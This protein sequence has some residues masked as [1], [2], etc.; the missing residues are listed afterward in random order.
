MSS[1]SIAKTIAG[2][3]IAGVALASA[4][5]FNAQ[6]ISNKQRN[7][8]KS[9]A[10]RAAAEKQEAKF[11]RQRSR[12]EYSTKGTSGNA[13]ERF[14]QMFDLYTHYRSVPTNIATE[15]TNLRTSLENSF[16]SIT[17]SRS[18]H[19]SVIV[20][21]ACFAGVF[22]NRTTQRYDD[23][24]DGERM[25]EKLQ[26]FVGI[27]VED[28][29][30][31]PN[32][33]LGLGSMRLSPACLV[34]VRRFLKQWSQSYNVLD[35]FKLSDPIQVKIQRALHIKFW[36]LARSFDSAGAVDLPT[37]QIVTFFPT[38]VHKCELSDYDKEMLELHE[39]FT[40]EMKIKWTITCIRKLEEFGL[41][42]TPTTTYGTSRQ[43][44]PEKSRETQISQYCNE[45]GLPIVNCELLPLDFIIQTSESSIT[46][47]EEQ[48][49][50]NK[51][52]LGF[53]RV[54]KHH[55]NTKN[56][57]NNKSKTHTRDRLPSL[58]ESMQKVFEGLSTNVLITSFVVSN[59]NIKESFCG[60]ISLTSK[61][62]KIH[63]CYKIE[64]NLQITKTKNSWFNSHIPYVAP[65][66]IPDTA[67]SPQ[68]SRNAIRT[69]NRAI[70]AHNAQI[71][72]NNLIRTKRNQQKK[73]MKLMYKN[74]GWKLNDNQTLK[75]G[76]LRFP[77]GARV[78][79]NTRS[80]QTIAGI[81]C[82]G[83]VIAHHYMASEGRRVPYQIRLDN[84]ELVFAPLDLN[85]CIRKLNVEWDGDWILGKKL[86]FDVLTTKIDRDKM[87]DETGRI[88]T[89]KVGQTLLYRLEAL[90]KENGHRALVGASIEHSAALNGK[91]KTVVDV[92]D[93][94]EELN[95][96]DYVRL[97][98]LES[99]ENVKVQLIANLLK[100]V[101]PA[102]TDS[103]ASR[104][105]EVEEY[106]KALL[107]LLMYRCQTSSATKTNLYPRD[108]VAKQSVYQ[109]MLEGSPFTFAHDT[110]ETAQIENTLYQART[111]KDNYFR[112]NILFHDE[113]AKG[114]SD[115]WIWGC[116]IVFSIVMICAVVLIGIVNS[117]TEL[118]YSLTIT[119][120]TS[121]GQSVYPFIHTSLTEGTTSLKYKQIGMCL[122][123][124]LC[125]AAVVLSAVYCIRQYRRWGKFLNLMS[126]IFVETMGM[127]TIL[128]ALLKD[129]ISS[130]DT[131]FYAYHLFFPKTFW[132]LFQHPKCFWVGL[133]KNF[134][135]QATKVS[136]IMITINHLEE[137]CES[138]ENKWQDRL[139][140]VHLNKL[141]KQKV[142]KFTEV[143]RLLEIFD[144]MAT[145]KHVDL[146]AESVSMFW[147]DYEMSDSEDEK[148]EEDKDEDKDIN[149]IDQHE[150][151]QHETNKQSGTTNTTNTATSHIHFEIGTKVE[152]CTST[153]NDGSNVW[154]M[155]EVMTSND[156]TT[157]LQIKLLDDN[158]IIKAQPTSVT[159]LSRSK[160]K[161]YYSCKNAKKRKTHS[162][163]KVQRKLVHIEKVKQK[164]KEYSELMHSSNTMEEVLEI[165]IPIDFEKILKKRVKDNT[166][167][168]EER[169]KRGEATESDIIARVEAAENKITEN[170]DNGDVYFGQMEGDKPHGYGTSTFAHGGKYVGEYKN[171][172][173]DG[174]G[175]YTW[176]DGK[177]YVGQY[178]DGKMHGQGTHTKANGTILHSGEWENDK[179]MGRRHL[180]YHQEAAKHRAKGKRKNN[181]LNIGSEIRRAMTK[182]LKKASPNNRPMMLMN[183]NKKKNM[184][185]DE[186][187]EEEEDNENEEDNKDEEES[188]DE[189]DRLNSSKKL[190][191]ADL[192]KNHGYKLIRQKTHNVF[193]R[194]IRNEKTGDT[195]SQ[196]V[197]Q[198]KTPSDYRAVLN[199][200]AVL[201]RLAHEKKAFEAGLTMTE[202]EEQIQQQNLATLLKNERINQEKHEKLKM[203]CQ[204]E[205]KKRNDQEK[206]QVREQKRASRLLKKKNQEE[207][208]K[209]E[210]LIEFQKEA[211]RR[212]EKEEKRR[213][214][215]EKRKRYMADKEERNREI[216]RENE[217]KQVEAARE[218]VKKD[219][220]DKIAAQK[221]A[222]EEQ[223]KAQKRIEIRMQRE[224]EEKI[225]AQ[226]ALSMRMKLEKE[227]KRKK[228]EK[229]KELI[230][231]E[232]ARVVRRE[233]E[234]KQMNAAAAAKK[235]ATT[236]SG[237]AHRSPSSNSY[238][239]TYSSWSTVPT[240]QP[241]PGFNNTSSPPG[242]NTSSASGFNAASP[243]GFV[244]QHLEPQS[245]EPESKT[246]TLVW[247]D[248]FIL[249][250]RTE[251]Y[252]SLLIDEECTDLETLKL[253]T[254][255]DFKNL[256]IR[257]GA[258]LR[259][260]TFLTYGESH[261]SDTRSIK[262]KR[263]KVGRPAP[264][265]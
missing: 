191:V 77:I 247:F 140:R 76:E 120:L 107:K 130:G 93:L 47:A 162:I 201:R 193:R 60:R 44:Q 205:D 157:N 20:F 68:S 56:F 249:A 42:C 158:K 166:L 108:V 240:S 202:Y 220:E 241:P 188:D 222:A 82:S 25:Q 257:K 54:N 229:N 74:A 219:A 80:E 75:A 253:F 159:V 117:N 43:E 178:T 30:V 17:V 248:Q 242:F 226:Q 39:S 207:Q 260:L 126:L 127:Y 156:S 210:A 13:R 87:A 90:E 27:M 180:Q 145:A 53:V 15:L 2:V 81:W 59:F 132:K 67:P 262:K 203:I 243:P 246:D 121:F 252:R 57:H 142:L 99:K 106:L 69:Y 9:S 64:S 112:D 144:S 66:P 141:K 5:I 179:P 236:L 160:L 122:T 31:D 195:T 4:A 52:H 22:D 227:E 176:P 8:A 96:S 86:K 58:A 63:E 161:Y 136:G 199:Q 175:T 137:F 97:K 184:S 78:E 233:N 72:K 32:A 23:D 228:A 192:F 79:C 131:E 194:T 94:V 208:H 14:Q 98:D 231:L 237:T 221:R 91:L 152:V 35:G 189:F 239:N 62:F 111:A 198:A 113:D 104:E 100:I 150:T 143:Q 133:Y 129:A 114:A 48:S 92:L 34:V 12:G 125:Y 216:R 51:S 41:V 235:F 46:E 211:Q 172:K 147:E 183:G 45:H 148:E 71:T 200:K 18:S 19:D 84:D 223:C 259:M 215:E 6:Q 55:K 232:K 37:C 206:F 174:N 177:K 256:S 70:E 185:D 50:Q 238:A 204:Q 251:K 36:L 165:E 1:S 263:M 261:T 139:L 190:T 186:S 61:S 168:A 123:K 3:G 24:D 153:R 116:F 103:T 85:I 187:S 16:S 38:A 119:I 217:I 255:E 225:K 21:M 49:L 115:S 29:G 182:A 155:G 146:N 105:Q 26:D 154:K 181:G 149:D 212:E 196:T 88:L 109:G 11:N 245:M 214:K 167:S 110:S 135:S 164:A 10:E 209:A 230:R 65:P 258:R 28:L 138:I 7:Q 234:M 124:H 213:K 83:T 250:T 102:D 95:Q 254:E 169:W 197:T 40:D 173:P 264:R 118:Y 33:S 171:D 128:Q 101:P 89:K 73:K 224:A 134:G 170:Y 163:R 265:D 218:K 244:S 151:D